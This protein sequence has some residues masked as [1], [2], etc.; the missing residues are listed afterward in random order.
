[1]RGE[2]RRGAVDSTA[3][4]LGEG[5]VFGSRRFEELGTDAFRTRVLGLPMT[6]LRG[7]A[8][9]QL[10]YGTEHFTRR[11]AIP[12]SVQHLL[13]DVG[14]VQGLTGAAHRRRKA[15]FVGM[16]LGPEA[17]AITVVL[18]Q[19][20]QRAAVRWSRQERIELHGQ[21]Q[22]VLARTALRWA[23]IPLT[24]PHI[25]ERARELALLVD[26]VALVG[27]PV[28][29]ARLRRRRTE[30]WAAGL[31]EQVR[32]GALV[33]PPRSALAMIAHHREG[34]GDGELLDP[35]VAAVELINVLRPVVA[36]SR[37][38]AFAAV[39]LIV[40]PSWHDTFAASDETD[41]ENFVQEVRRYYPFFPAVPG[42]ARHAVTW[43]GHTFARGDRVV[44]DL[45]GTDHDPE[46]WSRPETFLPERFRRWDGDPHSLVAQGGGDV[47]T[48]HRCPGERITI[49]LMKEAV[50]QLT[51]GMTFS[52]PAQD[53][54]I[55]LDARGPVPA[56]PREGVL[57]SRV[58][59]APPAPGPA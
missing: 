57:L 22:G 42:R 45:Y 44:L 17:E 43:Q 29:W 35:S 51:R 1:M 54:S 3:A 39:A 48:N 46:L 59:A 31:V 49:E 36:V 11:G 33:P 5:Y 27:P 47:R 32:S 50:R 8:A 56:L 25:R 34:E 21:V 40:H 10:F 28:W 9:S 26:R 13:Q 24:G 7:R 38:I 19:E 2:V 12:P 6:F 55:R 18:A 30:R 4:L 52:V 15:L 53:L 37:F 20:W 23:G 41:L 14:S 58:G 16:L